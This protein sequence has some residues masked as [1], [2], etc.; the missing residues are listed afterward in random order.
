MLLNKNYSVLTPT[1][2]KPF[3]GVQSLKKTGKVDITLD[4][5][6]TL[7]CA[8]KHRVKEK[9]F[10]WMYADQ[11][12][13]SSKIETV[14]GVKQVVSVKINTDEKFDFVD[15][16]QVEGVEYY[17]NGIVS[18]NCHFLG[19]S[20][21]LID[22]SKL[23][24]MTYIQPILSSGDV[25]VYKQPEKNR[26]YLAVVDTSRGAGIDYSAFVVFD[27]TE[28]PYTIAAKYRNNDIVS[29]LY[30]NIIYNVS[31][32]YNEAYI[33]VE[34]NDVGQQVADIL[35]NDLEYENVILTKVRGRAGQRIGEGGGNTRS[36]LGV[37]TTV[38][39]KRIGCA[40]FKSLVEN[41]KLIINDYDIIYELFRFIEINGKY[42]AEEGE[43]DDLVMCCVLFSW[44]VNQEYFKE[45][46]N[47]DARLEI[48]ANNQKII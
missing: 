44:L 13:T 1:G 36:S 20:N 19:S 43:H 45:I 17:T 28:I 30:P 40:N 27:I 29:L 18:H 8:L 3:F 38:Q 4:D 2:F 35:H 41:D 15:L 9:S 46:S 25:D 6:K 7:R 22:G 48:L 12:N 42:Q 39:V 47:N 21:T 32:H 10:G 31:R 11:L 33:L 23:A 34:T 24:Q 5:G 16:L 14:D 37:R 26:V